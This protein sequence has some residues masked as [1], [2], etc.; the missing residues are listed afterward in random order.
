MQE[1]LY[2]ITFHPTAVGSAYRISSRLA[3][4]QPAYRIIRIPAVGRAFVAGVQDFKNGIA[5]VF[6]LSQIYLRNFQRIAPFGHNAAPISGST[7]FAALPGLHRWEI[8]RSRIS[9]HHQMRD[10]TNPAGGGSVKVII[11]VSAEIGGVFTIAQ[12]IQFGNKAIISAL[13]HFLVGVGSDRKILIC[14]ISRHDQL[15]FHRNGNALP[16]TPV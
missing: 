16:P 13:E 2:R 15:V 6:I 5:L 8:G 3:H 1:N 12:R 7:A 9:A 4:H 14:G 10:T 11:T